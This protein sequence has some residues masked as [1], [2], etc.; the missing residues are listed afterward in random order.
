MPIVLP[1]ESW[2]HYFLTLWWHREFLLRVIVCFYRKP[3]PN[4]ALGFSSIVCK[5]RT[6]VVARGRENPCKHETYPKAENNGSKRRR[7]S[8]CMRHH[9]VR[10]YPLAAHGIPSLPSDKTTLS[11]P[12]ARS[13]APITGSDTLPN[14]D[15]QPWVSQ[16]GASMGDDPAQ[17]RPLHPRKPSKGRWAGISI[18]GEG[19]SQYGCSIC[20]STMSISLPV[21]PSVGLRRF[22]GPGRLV[23]TPARL[24][25]PA[26][27][28]PSFLN[29]RRFR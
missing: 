6:T 24:G 26:K 2:K 29:S 17:G 10:I 19:G 18:P 12:L 7:T 28:A 3:K 25:F 11:I 16:D 1:G 5:K 21:L 9:P 15:N 23:V 4:P 20:C 22:S 8:R 27:T 13:L 14:R